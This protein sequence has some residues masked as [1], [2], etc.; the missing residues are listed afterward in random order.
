MV[1]HSTILGK[2]YPALEEGSK[3]KEK[4]GKTGKVT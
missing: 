4:K 3:R 2:E 1:Q